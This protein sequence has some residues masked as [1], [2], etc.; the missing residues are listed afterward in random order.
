[1]I[2]PGTE[3]YSFLTFSR[4]ITPPFRIEYDVNAKGGSISS[5]LF[6]RANEVG[7]FCG[8]NNRPVGYVVTSGR[9]G[10]SVSREAV[11][12]AESKGPPAIEPEK[13][14]HVAVQFLPPKISV[15]VNGKPAVEYEDRQWLTAPDTFSFM[16]DAWSLPQI[17]NVRIY[18]ANAK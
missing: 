17:D 18:T 7:I 8:I 1:M 2:K 5:V 9:G 14:C 15:L 4:K 12:V 16:G 3:M 10:C 13:W 11:T 6:T